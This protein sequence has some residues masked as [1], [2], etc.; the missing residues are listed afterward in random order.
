MDYSRRG[1]WPPPDSRGWLAWL[2]LQEQGVQ[3]PGDRGQAQGKAVGRQCQRLGA[4][5][6]VAER[7]EPWEHRVGI[8]TLKWRL[9]TWEDSW[10]QRGRGKRGSQVSQ[11][12]P[13]A[14]PIPR[15]SA[16]HAYS[17]KAG[18][19]SGPFESTT[20]PLPWGPGTC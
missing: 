11:R 12:P 1:T 13:S 17:P 6:A 5:Q 4:L 16:L 7:G 8:C 14:F 2:Q 18:G 3:G 9:G 10:G 15:A 19:P 20:C